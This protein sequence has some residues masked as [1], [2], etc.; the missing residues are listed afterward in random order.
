MYLIVGCDFVVC[1]CFCRMTSHQLQTALKVSFGG[2]DASRLSGEYEE[3]FLSNA[4]DIAELMKKLPRSGSLTQ[5][6]AQQMV[7]NMILVRMTACFYT[8]KYVGPRLLVIESQI[9]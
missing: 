8:K 3:F 2:Q 9:W 5:L 1:V 4:D 6:Q 7:S